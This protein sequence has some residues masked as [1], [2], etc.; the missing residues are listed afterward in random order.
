MK[1][2]VRRFAPRTILAVLLVLFAVA[3]VT[4]WAAEG[5]NNDARN[6]IDLQ[7]STNIQ[8]RIHSKI[9]LNKMR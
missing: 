8:L 7:F 3:A 1:K 9:I 5:N 4:A 6:E 2:I